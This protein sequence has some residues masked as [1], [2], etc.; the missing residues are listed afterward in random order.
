MHSP[1]SDDIAIDGT[2]SRLSRKGPV[3]K[4][5]AFLFFSRYLFRRSPASMIRP[6]TTGPP[7]SLRLLTIHTMPRFQA[8]SLAL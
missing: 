3:V 8:R 4:S 5:R 6:D 7:A 2:E 1:L